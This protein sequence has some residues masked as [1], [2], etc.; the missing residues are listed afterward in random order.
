M[1]LK[2]WN[3]LYLITTLNRRFFTTY[4]NNMNKI[5]FFCFIAVA[6]S[7]IVQQYDYIIVGAGWAGLGACSK[8]KA[9]GA[10]NILVLEAKN[11]TGGRCTKFIYN[12]VEQDLGASFIQQ[13]QLGNAINGLFKVSGFNKTDAWFGNETEWYINKTQVSAASR[14]AALTQYKNFVSYLKNK[15]WETNTDEPLSLTLS[16]YWSQAN[17][18]DNGTASDVFKKAKVNQTLQIWAIDNGADISSLSTWQYDG[19]FDYRGS[20]DFTV[21]PSYSNFFQYLYSTKCSGVQTNLGETVLKVDY[22]GS[23]INVTTDKSFYLTKKLMLSPSIGILQASLKNWNNASTISFNPAL[24]ADKQTAINSIGFGRFEKLYVTFTSK[25]WDN[26]SS[27]LHFICKTPPCAFTEAWVV[28][29][30][31]NTILFWI[32]GS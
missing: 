28:P 10:K 26:N 30:V 16:K 27:T 4:N 8:L 9:G 15:G 19:V 21:K 5:F 12:V 7:D 2:Y 1:F 23:F 17:L 20:T 18:S 11:R 32:A 6:F 22:S 29:N 24:P 31:A 3:V 13:I 25:F 14:A